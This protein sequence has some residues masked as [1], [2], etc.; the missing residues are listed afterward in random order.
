MIIYLDHDEDKEGGS[1]TQ[2]NAE[3]PIDKTRE[4]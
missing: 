4:K 1:V 3:K 2:L